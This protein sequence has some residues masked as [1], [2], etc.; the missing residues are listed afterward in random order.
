MYLTFSLFWL[1]DYN[2][3]KVRNR[4]GAIQLNQNYL[5]NLMETKNE[6]PSQGPS[7]MSTGFSDDVHLR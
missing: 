3:L 5:K 1:K 4:F 7:N 6:H 2:L